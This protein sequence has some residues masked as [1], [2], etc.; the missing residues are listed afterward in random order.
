MAIIS[1]QEK[2]RRRQAVESVIGTN[3]MEGIVLD[4][5]TRALMRRFE[6]GEIEIEELSAAIDRHVS[7]MDIAPQISHV[8]VDR[9]AVEQTAVDAA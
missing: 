1:E 7:E 6:A 9:I 5:P 4:A 3:A 8:P 2:L